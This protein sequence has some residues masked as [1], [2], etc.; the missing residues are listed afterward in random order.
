MSNPADGERTR[1]AALDAWRGIA[2]LGVVAVHASGIIS[3]RIDFDGL[4]L[5]KLLIWSG[6]YGVELFFVLSGLTVTWNYQMHCHE[7]ARPL[8]AYFTRRFFRLSPMYYLTLVVL[9]FIGYNN[10]LEPTTIAPPVDLKNLALH[11]SYMHGLFPEYIRSILSP[12]WSLTPEVIF[13]VTVPMVLWVCRTPWLRLGFFLAMVVLSEWYARHW[14]VVMASTPTNYVWS[15]LAPPR[16]FFLFAGG[17]VLADVFIWRNHGLPPDQQRMWARLGDAIFAAAVVG[18]Y[19]LYY[20]DANPLWTW[21]TIVAGVLAYCL[22]SN[23]L[24]LLL[25]WKPLQHLGLVSYSVFLIHFPI[26]DWLRPHFATLVQGVS[27]G[28]AYSGFLVVILGTSWMVAAQTYRWIER[29]GIALGTYI[30][31]RYLEKTTYRLEPPEIAP[32]E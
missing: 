23:W 25:G 30:I 32:A 11:F 15:T 27:P 6:R 1:V 3:E 21:L 26:I 24:Q 5:R 16:L 20:R 19:V 10:V 9:V 12:A 7:H 22:H 14:D 4:D 17:M 2:I 18:F 31:R 8:A 28:I 29:P 13:Y